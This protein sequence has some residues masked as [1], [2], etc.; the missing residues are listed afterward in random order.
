MMKQSF[1]ADLYYVEFTDLVRISVKISRIKHVLH[2][3]KA[4]LRLLIISTNENV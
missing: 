2:I 3:T 4:S 1:G